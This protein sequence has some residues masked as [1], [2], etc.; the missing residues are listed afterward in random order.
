MSVPCNLLHI[1]INLGLNLV[2]LDYLLVVLFGDLK[3]FIRSFRFSS[4]LFCFD[5]KLIRL[6][7]IFTKA[8]TTVPVMEINHMRSFTTRI[9]GGE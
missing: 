8:F 7:L 5:L 6:I 4:Y 1:L 2:E 9:D 3:I